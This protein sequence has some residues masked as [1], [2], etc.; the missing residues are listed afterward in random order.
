MLHRKIRESKHFERKEYREALKDGYLSI[1]KELSEGMDEIYGMAVLWLIYWHLD[2][3]FAFDPSGCTA[4]S[5][6][7]TPEG[8]ILVV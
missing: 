4:V 7:I 6:L 3:N 8:K 1:D 5:A 2:G